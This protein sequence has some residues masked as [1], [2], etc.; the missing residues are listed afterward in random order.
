MS[1]TVSAPLPPRPPVQ[2]RSLTS[3]RQMVDVALRLL[4]E[5]DID[6]ISIRDIVGAS[7]T[8]NGS[9]YHRFGTKENF[10]NYLIDDMLERRESGAIQQLNDPSIAFDALSE[11]LARSAMANFQ[12]H[13]GLL[14][15]AIR[16]HIAG[17]D[18]WN[19]ISKMSRRIVVLYLE[20]A[21]AFVG[22]PLDAAE[23][24]RVYFAF[25]WLYG[26]LAYRTLGLNSVHGYA[27]PDQSFEAETIRNFR[28]LIDQALPTGKQKQNSA[29]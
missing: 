19:R 18:C 13:A 2:Q 6:Q 28:H 15:S 3:H 4:D 7:G 12:R 1:A 14:R 25:V 11:I 20:R 23:A 5:R 26:L 10:F 16:R 17:D 22:R 21:A 24:E 27:M 29:S 9:F 8:S